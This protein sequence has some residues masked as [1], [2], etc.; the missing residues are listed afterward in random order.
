MRKAWKPMGVD[1]QLIT[2]QLKRVL[3]WGTRKHDEPYEPTY[4]EK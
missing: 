4:G 1:I 2:P 3:A